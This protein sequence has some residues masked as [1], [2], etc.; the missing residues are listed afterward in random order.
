MTDL[1]AGTIILGLLAAILV[2][3]WVLE[4]ITNNPLGFIALIMLVAGV[5]SV[6]LW[7]GLED[8]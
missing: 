2:A 4:L 7:R 5:L 6:L 3:G 8:L 1:K